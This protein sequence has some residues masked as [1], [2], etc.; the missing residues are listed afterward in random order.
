VCIGESAFRGCSSLE[1]IIIPENSVEQFKEMLPNYLWDKLY[2]LKKAVDIKELDRIRES[3]DY[4]L[5]F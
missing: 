3:D 4:D 1:S 2:Y 5:P